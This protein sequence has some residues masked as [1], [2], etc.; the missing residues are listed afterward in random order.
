MTIP[1]A[2]RK[3][4]KLKEGDKVLFIQEGDKIIFANASIISLEKI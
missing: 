2:I 1:I 4:L 3:R